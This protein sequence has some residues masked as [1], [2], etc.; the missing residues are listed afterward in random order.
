MA[1]KIVTVGTQY[2]KF[3]FEVFEKSYRMV[4]PKTTPV[5]STFDLLNTEGSIRRALQN[6]LLTLEAGI[7]IYKKREEAYAIKVTSFE[8]AEGYSL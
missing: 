6:I 2:G 1:G 5:F 3:K 4:E 8:I 7:E